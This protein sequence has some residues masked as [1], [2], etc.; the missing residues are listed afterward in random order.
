LQSKCISIQLF[1]HLL[2]T[3]FHIHSLC[4]R[5][6]LLLIRNERSNAPFQSLK[7]LTTPGFQ[8]GDGSVYDFSVVSKIAAVP[9]NTSIGRANAKRCSS[10]G[11][12]E[13]RQ[14]GN[15]GTVFKQQLIR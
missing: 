11:F 4:R 14:P 9:R 15:Q 5:C 7:P 13:R 12:K 2:N 1:K 6:L 8:Q 3:T 10:A